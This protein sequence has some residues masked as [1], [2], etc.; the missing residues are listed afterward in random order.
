MDWC[1]AGSNATIKKSD[2]GRE[3][4][5]SGSNELSEFIEMLDFLLLIR[6]SVVFLLLAFLSPFCRRRPSRH[7]KI[8]SNYL[9]TVSKMRARIAM[10][11]GRLDE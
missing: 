6:E 10:V 3:R 8:Q 2:A 4:R 9:K 11:N 1:N 7:L 5:R